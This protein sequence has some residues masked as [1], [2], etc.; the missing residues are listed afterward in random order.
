MHANY[1]YWR[2]DPSLL[3]DF[4]LLLFTYFFEELASQE[5]KDKFAI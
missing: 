5:I 2:I 3:K 1:L 4:L